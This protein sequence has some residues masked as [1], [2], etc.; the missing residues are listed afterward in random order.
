MTNLKHSHNDNVAQC[1]PLSETARLIAEACL[2]AK[3]KE[4][5]VL[6]VSSV[7]DLSDNFVIVSGRSDRHVQGIANKVLSRM[8]KAG[9]D[10]YA[11]EGFDDGHWVLID[12]E[13]VVL[14]IFYEPTRKHYDIEG[15]WMEARQVDLNALE[16]LEAA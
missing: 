5:V 8:K 9:I 14:H 11:V 2:E 6:D 3:G 12:F 10:A 16:S 4:L 1:Q 13:D 15:L 7:F